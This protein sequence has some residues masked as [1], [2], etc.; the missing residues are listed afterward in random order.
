MT[1]GD[2]FTVLPWASVFWTDSSWNA[3][4]TYGNEQSRYMVCGVFETIDSYCHTEDEVRVNQGNVVGK[5][6]GIH[7]LRF[8]SSIPFSQDFLKP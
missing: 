7:L 2:T 5:K 8:P 4:K 1:Q 6:M 3:Q